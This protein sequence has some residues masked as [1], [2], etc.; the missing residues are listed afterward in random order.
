MSMKTLISRSITERE[1][2]TSSSATVRRIT[3]STKTTKIKKARGWRG[4]KKDRG[5][6]W[7]APRMAL[8]YRDRNLFRLGAFGLWQFEFKDSVCHARLNALNVDRV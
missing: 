3:Y 8:P 4:A 7:S 1:R 2:S 5:A 6:K